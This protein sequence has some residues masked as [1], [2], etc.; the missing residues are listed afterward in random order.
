[1]DITQE[2][3]KQLLHYDPDTGMFMWKVTRGGVKI[4][5]IAGHKCIKNTKF[6][7]IIGL[8]NRIYRAHRLA[9]FYMTGYWPDEVDHEDGNGTNNKWDNLRD[10]DRQGNCRNM[11]LHNHNTSGLSGVSWRSQRN[12]WRSYITVNNKQMNL[13]H[14]NDFFEAVCIR[15]STENKLGFHG[16]HGSDRPL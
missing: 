14:Y 4:D 5:D 16:N 8:N 2:E 10:V 9:W 1:M 12:K 11:R 3:L 13:G 15:K 6:Y 7:V